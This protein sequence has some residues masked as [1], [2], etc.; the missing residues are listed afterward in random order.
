MRLPLTVTLQV[1]DAAAVLYNALNIADSTSASAALRRRAEIISIHVVDTA[2]SAIPGDLIPPDSTPPQVRMVIR[3][4]LDGAAEALLND[5]NTRLADTGLT[6]V[7][8][9]F[10]HELAS[11]YKSTI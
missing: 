8:L 5:L 7:S 3:Q 1:T 6:A 2:L 11:C 9:M 4:T 10:A